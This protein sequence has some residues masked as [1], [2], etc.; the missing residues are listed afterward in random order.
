MKV[1][2]VEDNPADARLIQETL[3]EVP[4]A[5]GEP[6]EFEPTRVAQLSEAL[7]M[8]AGQTFNVVLL[9]LGLA[10]SEGLET[11]ARV[12]E[13]AQGDVPVVVLTGLN[14][15]VAGL[16]AVRR[17][18]QDFMGKTGLEVE[19]LAR[20]LRFAVER[21]R[22]QKTLLGS[23]GRYRRLAEANLLQSTALASAAN[24]V[25][26][27]N[28]QGR[29]QWVNPAF[30]ALTGYQAEE[31]LGK[32]PRLLKSGQHP[33]EFYEGLWRTILEGKVW[34]GEFI[35]RRKDGSFYHDEHTI[36]PVRSNGGAI[37]HFVAIMQ[38]VTQRKKAEM[39]IRTLN[40][41]LDRRVRDRTALLEAANQE[42]EAFS[43]S[44]SHDLRAPLRHTAGFA[45]L[46]NKTAGPAL[47]GKS[48]HYLQQITDSV[49][50]MGQLIDDLLMFS[51]MGRDDL[52]REPLDLR[53]LAE[54]VIQQLQ[55]QIVGRIICWKVDRLPE[56]QADRSLL[57]QVLMN[58]FSNAVKYTRPR[59]TAEI[60]I[61]CAKESADEVV[62]F[63]RDNG[64]GF[65]MQY[66]GKLFGVFQRLHLDDEFEGTGIGL[67]SV[68]RIIARHGGR[69][70]AEGQV[71]GGA[72]FFISLPKTPQNT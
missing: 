56:V 8:L 52:R 20:T 24:G 31:V 4:H 7:R 29:I 40:D 27:T 3:A 63:V 13:K 36:T 25:V 11:L 1:L 30:E 49:R 58:L 16:E 55:S 69:T 68:R 71:D 43:Y 32:N 28:R 22:A 60:E 65:D 19:L 45:E 48:R 33:L 18:A 51:R 59:A 46:L 14:D 41:E 57:R 72:R 47:T 53:R 10:D 2:L 15:E 39:E 62:V 42:L 9:D 17:G 26:I 6:L 37:T 23:Q 61:G 34:R 70:W 5:P 21:H 67:A 44:V 64:V 38:D 35:N 12:L 54:E 66:A 50:Q